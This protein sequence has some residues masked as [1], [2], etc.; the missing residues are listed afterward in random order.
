MDLKIKSKLWIEFDGWPVFGRDRGFLLEAIETDGE[1]IS[2]DYLILSAGS[3]SHFFG[4]PGVETHAYGL[5]TLEEAVA[6]KNHII[7]SFEQAARETDEDRLVRLR[8]M[9]IDARLGATVRE[10]TPESVILMG[11]EAIG[12]FGSLFTL[13]TSSVSATGWWYSLTGPGIICSTNGRSALFSLPRCPPFPNHPVVPTSPVGKMASHE[14]DQ[15]A[16]D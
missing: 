7:C 5:K 3:I 4:I 10:V 14:D 2:Y 11:Q 15:R 12:Y 16:I 6:L 1:T 13:P 8:E 9:G